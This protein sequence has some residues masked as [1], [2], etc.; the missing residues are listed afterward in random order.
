MIKRV[1]LPFDLSIFDVHPRP[2]YYPSLPIIPD[3]RASVPLSSFP[4]S[5][6][7]SL[8]FLPSSPSLYPTHRRI[9]VDIHII[10]LPLRRRLL[11]F[12][13]LACFAKSPH[14]RKRHVLLWNKNVATS[15]AIT[16]AARAAPERGCCARLD[17]ERRRR[18]RGWGGR[19]AGWARGRGEERR[20]RR[21]EG[22]VR[23]ERTALG[24]GQG[25]RT[26][27]RV[28]EGAT[29]GVE[30]EGA[31]ADAYQGWRIVE[32]WVGER[33]GVERDSARAPER[34]LGQTCT[35]TYICIYIYTWLCVRV[36]ARES[37]A[38]A[39]RDACVHAREKSIAP[40]DACNHGHQLYVYETS[41]SG[42]PC[43]G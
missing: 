4:S 1:N 40:F 33:V 27:R 25:G 39:F 21:G 43:A 13:S 16:R 7:A 6:S 23:A 10:S 14:G 24:R 12:S 19:K 32:G 15:N 35:Y 2:I 3:V 37:L 30:R 29:R 8:L 26:R 9:H 11:L 31:R 36:C 41:N 38:R 5:L 22:D 18:R 28:S 17:G 20:D 42:E 34:W